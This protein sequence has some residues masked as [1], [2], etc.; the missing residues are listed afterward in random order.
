MH[1]APWVSKVPAP[2]LWGDT[3][4]EI[5][6]VYQGN[7]WLGP[8]SR[9]PVREV[10][11]GQELGASGDSLDLGSQSR[12]YS[13]NETGEVCQGSGE[14]PSA[15]RWGLGGMQGSQELWASGGLHGI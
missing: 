9:Q 7:G 4:K 15:T 14:L 3:A 8:A 10:Q 12:R 1:G 13:V 2:Q 11:G 6:M 5:W